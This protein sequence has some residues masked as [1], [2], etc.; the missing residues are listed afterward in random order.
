MI[1][2]ARNLRVMYGAVEALKGI[3]FDLLKGEVATIIGANGAGKTTIL[4]SIMGIIKIASGNIKTAFAGQIQNLPPHKIA[5]LGIGYVPEGREILT[6][7]TVE[8]NL[9]IGGFVLTNKKKF[10]ERLKYVYEK[11][12]VLQ[13]KRHQSGHS[14]SGGEQ[15]MLAI[16]RALML[17]PQILLMDEPSLGLAPLLI[18]QVFQL[19]EDFR[20]DGYSTLLIEQNARRALEI[21]ERGYVMENGV[22]VVTDSSQN[23]INNENIK[24]AY[25]GG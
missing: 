14:L 15:Q 19:I 11:F 1:L 5:R 10:V 6:R 20:H 8:D 7:L 18:T 4:K 2:E 3:S 23:L 16:A 9:V 13:S 12:P 24:K 22:L 21:S 25:L 17:S